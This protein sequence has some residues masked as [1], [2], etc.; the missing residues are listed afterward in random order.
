VSQ[1]FSRVV[2]GFVVLLLP[3]CSG[4]RATRTLGQREIVV[5]F[6]L[7]TTLADKAKVAGLCSSLP[8]ASPEPLPTSENSPAARLGEVRFRV[9]KADNTQILQLVRCAQGF[10]EVRYVEMPSDQ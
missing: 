8:V 1:G 9:D 5:H 6:V 3:V 2:V 10:P 7:G 4:C